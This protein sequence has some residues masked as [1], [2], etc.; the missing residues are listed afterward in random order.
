MEEKPKRG[1]PALHP[2][3]TTGS[4]RAGMSRAYV[5]ASGG[6]RLEIILPKEETEALAHIMAKTG[7]VTRKDTILRLI[8]EEAEK[9]RRRKK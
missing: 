3:G 8:G 1:R 6:S 5:L 2:P 7:E 9:L 4:D